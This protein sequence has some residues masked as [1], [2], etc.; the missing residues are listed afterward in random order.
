MRPLWLLSVSDGFG[1]RN[2]VEAIARA[3]VA[4]VGGIGQFDR[5]IVQRPRAAPIIFPA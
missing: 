3:I 5:L 2:D 4:D 1:E